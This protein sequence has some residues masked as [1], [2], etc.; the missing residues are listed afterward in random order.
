MNTPLLK[1]S[2]VSII[3]SLLIVLVVGS[4]IFV[5]C[6]SVGS[7]ETE[8]IE[9][10]QAATVRMDVSERA[11]FL[12]DSLATAI[13]AHDEIV[14]VAISISESGEESILVLTKTPVESW[15]PSKKT[16]V[17]P[18]AGGI[19]VTVLVTGEITAPISAQGAGALVGAAEFSRP[20]PIGVSTSL[21]A[22]P[23]GT[24]GA[25]VADGT[26]LYALS[27]NHVYAVVN[28]A[29]IGSAIIQL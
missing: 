11:S 28:Q 13:L 12:Q 5:G 8:P 23:T 21:G 16:I 27:N 29:E 24:I 3:R 25:R 17:P 4:V 18:E 22:G 10:D 15:A 6:D 14:G 2:P 1:S 7:G 19:S 26:N 9:R 20:V